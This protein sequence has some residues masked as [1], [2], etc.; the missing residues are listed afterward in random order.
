MS[1]DQAA[2]RHQIEE[3][4]GRLARIETHLGLAPAPTRPTPSPS[5]AAPP[6]DMVESRATEPAGNPQLAAD[7][8]ATWTGARAPDAPETPPAQHPASAPYGPPSIAPSGSQTPAPSQPLVPLAPPTRPSRP[9]APSASPAHSPPTTP[10]RPP[11]RPPAKDVATAGM[12]TIEK[13]IGGRWYAVIGAVIVVIGVGLFFKLAVQQGWIV[14]TPS[15]R[16]IGGAIFGAL[17]LVAGEIARRRVGDSAAAGLSAA[18]IGVA[19]ASVYAAYGLYHILGQVGAFATLA[20]VAGLGIFI[21]ARARMVSVAIVSLVCGYLTPILLAQAAPRPMVI[22]AYLFIL[23]IV[24]LALSAWRGGRFVALRSLVWWATLI[25]GGI[26]SLRYGSNEPATA[27]VFFGLVWSAVHAELAISSG[28]FGLVPGAGGN[29]S[30]DEEDEPQVAAISRPITGK[31]MLAWRPLSSSFSTTTWAALLGT[32]ILREWTGPPDWLA[33]AGFAVG[34]GML[35][36]VLAGHLRVLRDR[37]RTDSQRLGAAL[38]VQSGALL[39]AATAMAVQ[40]PAQAVFW[41]AMGVAVVLGGR[42]IGSRGLDVYGLI[43]LTLATGRAVV[44]ERVGLAGTGVEFA[45]MFLTLWGALVASVA[46]GWLVIAFL[47]RRSAEPRSGWLVVSNAA[48]AIGM[49]LLCVALQ[50]QR[51]SV[52]V[53]LVTIATLG[54]AVS[55]LGWFLSSRGLTAYAILVLILATLYAFLRG[56]WRAGVTGP[57]EPFLGLYLT[58]WSGTI[59]YLA[60][61]WFVAAEFNKRVPGRGFGA[62]AAA[63]AGMA[64]ALALGALAH[65]SAAG[66]SVLI[67]WLAVALAA[68]AARFVEPRLSLDRWGLLGV[69]AT[70]VAWVVVYPPWGNVWRV[71]PAAAGLHPGLWT[72]LAIAGSFALFTRFLL[73]RLPP[74]DPIPGVLRT[75]GSAA[76][77]AMVFA[78]TSLEV[79]RSAALLANDRTVQRAAVSAWW[80][81]F[82]FALIIL[83]FALAGRSRTDPARPRGIPACRQIGLAL[84]AVAAAKALVFDLGDVDPLWRVISLVGVGLLMLAVSVTYAKVSA[85]LAPPKAGAPGPEGA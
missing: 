56:W 35:A 20:G 47:L 21:G 78:A 58:A 85:R 43:V 61:S 29:R 45:G 79:G 75:I 80:G 76:M 42:W 3:I 31:A 33:A 50:D 55:A 70:V 5:P 51:A 65:E 84:L 53:P 25:L 38:M 62:L 1:D 48:V 16:C 9:V 77:T 40:G 81:V 7:L 28:R 64:V 4:A 14:F 82:A 66:V 57:S 34:S 18:G 24:G 22:P 10:V 69:V 15:A 73:D 37:P 49:T 32:L 63:C 68:G 41:L 27:L 6:T 60:A 8:L 36:M 30:G 44:W 19:F 11:R 17:L 54:A 71:N 2:L 67:A 46:G 52:F 26:W 13:L 59:A 23:L 12:A 74:E 72:G 39:I 83:G